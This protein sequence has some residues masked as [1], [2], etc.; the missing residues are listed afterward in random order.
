M[1]WGLV[2]QS[3]DAV[4]ISNITVL[5]WREIKRLLGAILQSRSMLRNKQ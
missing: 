2:A 1:G 3:R 4:I 5:V